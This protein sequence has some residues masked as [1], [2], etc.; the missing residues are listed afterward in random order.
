LAKRF[1]L[2]QVHGVGATPSACFVRP[3]D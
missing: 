3:L 2:G 1:K